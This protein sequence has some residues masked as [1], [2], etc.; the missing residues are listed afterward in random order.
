MEMAR[1]KERE[2][3]Y[4]T[5]EYIKLD[6]LLKWVDFAFSGAEAKLLVLDGK[7][8]VNGQLET[9]RGRKIYEGDTVEAEGRLIEVKNEV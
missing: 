9:R 6:Q 2:I 8:K 7:V 3:V 4:I 1:G 5:T